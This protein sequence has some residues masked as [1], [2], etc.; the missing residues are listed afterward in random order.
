MNFL[1]GPS[2]GKNYIFRFLAVDASPLPL[3]LTML[4]AYL[5]LLVMLLVKI[6]LLLNGQGSRP[7]LLIGRTNSK[8]FAVI[9][10]TYVASD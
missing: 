5:L 1:N 6:I 8:F 9:L 7:L 4:P 2:H 10:D 3:A